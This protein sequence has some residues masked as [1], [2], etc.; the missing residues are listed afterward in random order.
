MAAVRDFEAYRLNEM[1]T[2]EATTK[3]CSKPDS[4]GALE[5]IENV[6]ARLHYHLEQTPN[7]CH[8]ANLPL[9]ATVETPVWSIARIQ[10]VDMGAMPEPIAEL[11]RR[12]YRCTVVCRCRS[13]RQSK[14]A[15]QFLLDPVITDID[16][17][18]KHPG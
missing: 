18:K 11:L 12:D 14:K 1:A 10:P 6:A 17:A 13:R 5:M 8:S 16:T 4:E 7:V 9:G 2:G 3:A 15:L